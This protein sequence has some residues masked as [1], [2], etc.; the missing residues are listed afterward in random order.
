[1]TKTKNNTKYETKKLVMIKKLKKICYIERG[2]RGVR[3]GLSSSIG[4]L[5]RI[6]FTI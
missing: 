1:M 4:G 5:W 3:W 2:M 6:L